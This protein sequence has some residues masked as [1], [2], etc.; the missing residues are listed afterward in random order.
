MRK[1][2]GGID[3]VVRVQ[4][5]VGMRNGGNAESLL[6]EGPPG[7]PKQ[8][9]MP[10]ERMITKRRE[11]NLFPIPV[12][13]DKPMSSEPDV[14][15]DLNKPGPG[16][17]FKEFLFTTPTIRPQEVYPIDPDPGIQFNPMMQ[18][19]NGGI[20]G[21]INASMIKPNGILSIQKV[22]DI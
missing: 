17:R 11:R 7:G 21:L 20:S 5:P 22:Y 3:S 10:D 8:F 16:Y 9:E 15:L 14:Q 4:I 1:I 2:T 6:A 13:D 19:Q 12:P 18:Q